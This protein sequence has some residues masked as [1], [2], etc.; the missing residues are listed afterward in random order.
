MSQSSTCRHCWQPILSTAGAG[1]PLWVH[2][3]T[4]RAVCAG[5]GLPIAEPVGPAPAVQ[6]ALFDPPPVAAGLI[7]GG[8]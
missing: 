5:G 6:A 2:A 8:R 4:R 3:G 7:G 1:R